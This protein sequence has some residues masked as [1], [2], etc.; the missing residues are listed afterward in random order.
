VFLPWKADRQGRDAWLAT[1]SL[2]AV[3]AIVFV[4]TATSGKQEAVF[5][6]WGFAPARVLAGDAPLS[7][8]TSIFLHA[9]VVH[10][11][12]NLLYLGI[13]GARIE[14]VLG[15]WKF[16]AFFVACGLGGH[17]GHALAEPGSSVPVVGA[18]GAIAGVLGAYLIGFP[19][20]KVTTFLYLIFVTGNFRLPA[21]IVIGVWFL[22]QLLGSLGGGGGP[23]AW[24][25]HLG[26]FA[27]GL[28][29]FPL[30]ARRS[31]LR[32]SRW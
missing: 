29:A 25:E 10:L 3:D 32:S 21:A 30:I 4:L 18:S 12:A 2:I 19:D 31:A 20:A 17:L 24:F 15:T 13:F 26:G 7:A 22:A 5:R 8:L 23:I 1:A 14:G 27:V 16:V 28:L 11:A 6:E 9:N